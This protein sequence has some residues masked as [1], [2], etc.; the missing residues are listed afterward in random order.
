MEVKVIYREI[1]VKEPE[2]TE[3]IAA[4]TWM[5]DALTFVKAAHFPT[6]Y[7]IHYGNEIIFDTTGKSIQE[8]KNSYLAYTEEDGL[9]IK[10]E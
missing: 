4:F 7:Q 1:K 6:D 2:D 5:S 9:A 3:F 10:G 8:V